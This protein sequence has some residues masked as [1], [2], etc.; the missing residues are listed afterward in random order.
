MAGMNEVERLAMGQR[1]RALY[2]REFE[3]QILLG[4]MEAWLLDMAAGNKTARERA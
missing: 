2:A 4:R 3:R 1:G